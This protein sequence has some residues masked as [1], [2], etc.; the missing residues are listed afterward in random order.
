M[1]LTAGGFGQGDTSCPK[2][3]L[4]A[5]G[6][7][8]AAKMGCDVTACHASGTLHNEA[9]SKSSLCFPVMHGHPWTHSS[10]LLSDSQFA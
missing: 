8:Y 2:K 5:S 4:K 9:Q 3:L 7:I 1:P 6:P 10:F